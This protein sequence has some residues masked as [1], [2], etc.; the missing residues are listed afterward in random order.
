[1]TCAI[2][3]VSEVKR[4]SEMATYNIIIYQDQSQLTVC[5]GDVP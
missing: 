3:M 1:M 5:T 4:M 2:N